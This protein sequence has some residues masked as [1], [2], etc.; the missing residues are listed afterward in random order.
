MR[1]KNLAIVTLVVAAL[2]LGRVTPVLA[3]AVQVVPAPP[4]APPAGQPWVSPLSTSPA[5]AAPRAAPPVPVAR[6][7][8]QLSPVEQSEWHEPFKVVAK[9]GGAAFLVTW[10]L[11]ALLLLAASAGCNNDDGTVDSKCESDVWHMAIPVVG[12]F[13]VHDAGG[14]RVVGAVEGA[15][16]AL[17]AASF[18]GYELT[19]PKPVARGAKI[20][21]VPAI[22]SD[23]RAL[24]LNVSW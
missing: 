10:G 7:E 18:I 1:I 11:S 15:A 13:L 3:Q 12:P 23:V 5:P 4:A 19:M 14:F 24:A 21:V 6:L 8:P 22:G 17:F 16:V 9:I 20:S 2:L